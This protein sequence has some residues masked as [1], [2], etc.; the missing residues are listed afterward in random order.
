MDNTLLNLE[1][2]CCL[3]LD[4]HD[5]EIVFFCDGFNVKKVLSLLPKIEKITLSEFFLE[6]GQGESY[7][8][9]ERKDFDTINS[10]SNLMNIL[11]TLPPETYIFNLK[12]ASENLSLSIHDNRHLNISTRTFDE[13]NFTGIIKNFL[14]K[15]FY[16]SDEN[17][18]HIVSA[19]NRNNNKYVTI[20]D[21]GDILNVYENFDDYVSAN[22]A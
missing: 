18:S 7:K 9:W 10:M 13:I 4:K 12:F 3:L 15:I 11:S 8:S 22:Q 6:I 21:K 2:K 14:S 5:N 17:C 1:G 19:L 16:F 20:N